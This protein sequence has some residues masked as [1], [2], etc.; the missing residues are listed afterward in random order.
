DVESIR[1]TLANGE[2]FVASVFQTDPKNDLA[3]IQITPRTPLKVIPMG[4]SSDL[5]LAEDVIAIC[6]AYGYTDS[7]TRRIVSALHR[8]VEAGDDQAYFD[9][10]QTDAAI[11][12]GN[13]GGPL[14]NADGE[15]IGINVAIRAG[16]TK[17]GFAIPID[18]A[19]AAT[20][21][22]F[23]VERTAKLYHG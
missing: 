4:T 8:D 11:N 13:S 14:I 20:A 7:I 1:V 19:R 18:A 2:T 17:I 10:I 3:L 22:M 9:L 23:N 12:P 21:K 15:V 16:A 6:N 5:M